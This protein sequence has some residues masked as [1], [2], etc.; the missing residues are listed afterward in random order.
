[1]NKCIAVLIL[2]KHYF[3]SGGFVLVNPNKC[4]KL[5][6]CS[7]EHSFRSL[8]SIFLRSFW[9]CFFFSTDIL[10]HIYPPSF[11][12]RTIRI[13]NWRM[14]LISQNFKDWKH[15]YPFKLSL[16]NICS[17]CVFKWIF[18]LFCSCYNWCFVV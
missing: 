4:A 8:S 15:K 1:M 12:V 3:F 13:K 18:I 2:Y 16:I 6:I 11:S 7:S 10:F 9:I 5:R 14:I 17:L